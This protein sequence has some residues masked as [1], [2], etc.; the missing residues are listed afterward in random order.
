MASLL[1][2]PFPSLI[3]SPC[4]GICAAK[5]RSLSGKKQEKTRMTKPKF[6]SF[7]SISLSVAFAFSQL[8]V[9]C[10]SAMAQASTGLIRGLVTD[11]GGAVVANATVIAKN[12]ATG[13]TSPSYKTT[14][15]GVYVIPSLISGKYEL[16]IQGAG[17]K[18]AVF[19]DVD[20][21]L[22][23]E[24]VIDAQLQAGGAAETV[25]VTTSTETTIEKDTSQIS[26]SFDSRKVQDL[27]SN[28]AG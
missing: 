16:T 8:F 21:K 17:F 20:V 1:R 25:T 27:P 6:R 18:T 26:S 14:S 9:L 13:V 11:Q 15:D 2:L 23:I 5:L 22:G 19:T 12:S 4:T 28:L 24:T 7:A 10:G 3:A